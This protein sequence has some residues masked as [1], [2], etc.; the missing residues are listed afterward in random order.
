MAAALRKS[1]QGDMRFFISELGNTYRDDNFYNQYTTARSAGLYRD[2]LDQI[3]KRK[4][5]V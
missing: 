2:R 5:A 3:D 1:T 4:T